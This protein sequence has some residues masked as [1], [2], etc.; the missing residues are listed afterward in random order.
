M[1]GLRPDN[2]GHGVCHDGQC[3]NLNRSSD[4]KDESL[5]ATHRTALTK[6]TLPAILSGDS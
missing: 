2:S 5:H 4:N 1:M 6:F 3:G